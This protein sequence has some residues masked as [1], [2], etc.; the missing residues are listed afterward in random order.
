MGV[1]VTFNRTC[2]RCG[3][4]FDMRNVSYA[5]GLP[6]VQSNPLVLT[7]GGKQVFSFDDLCGTCEGVVGKL[8]KRLSLDEEEKKKDES[9]SDGS[10]PKKDES[11]K[12]DEGPK[13]SEEVPKGVQ[14][15]GDDE[16]DHPF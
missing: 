11:A 12:T 13:T 8:I 6:K 9:A 5:E 1:H 7:H 16:K 15:E 2:D 4:P 10:K 3:K 14:S